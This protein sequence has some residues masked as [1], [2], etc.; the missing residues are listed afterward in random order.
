MEVHNRK[1]NLRIG[2]LLGLP[3][4][5][6]GDEMLEFGTGACR[7]TIMNG[8]AMERRYSMPLAGAISMY[9]IPHFHHSFAPHCR[10]NEQPILRWRRVGAGILLHNVVVVAFVRAK[11]DP[12]LLPSSR[13]T[14]HP[15]CLYP[16]Y[17]L[18]R[19]RDRGPVLQI[20][21]GLHGYPIRWKMPRRMDPKRRLTTPP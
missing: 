8:K 6:M 19:L 3:V 1:P 15:S 20:S 11:A 10:R 9:M 14:L 7:V 12:A 16:L 17:S 13:R 5:K 21:L 18:P 2:V 4:Y